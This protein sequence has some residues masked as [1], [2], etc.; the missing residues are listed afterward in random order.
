MNPLEAVLLFIA[1]LLPFHLLVQRELS[2]MREA[3]PSP[4]RG[5]AMSR[6]QIPREHAEV[7]G[8]Y[9]DCEIYAWVGFQGVRYRYERVVGHAYSSRVAERELFIEPGLLYVAE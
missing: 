4:R 3:P 5:V 6:K 8:Y 1:L 7:I 9:Q 2:R